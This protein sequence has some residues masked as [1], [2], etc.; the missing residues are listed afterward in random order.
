MS[1]RRIIKMNIKTRPEP[2]G[3]SAAHVECTGHTSRCKRAGCGGVGRWRA[4]ECGR[5]PH[6]RVT[7]VAKKTATAAPLAL[8]LSGQGEGRPI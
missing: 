2:H 4:N 1:L 7:A 3:F 5:C 6:P 8:F